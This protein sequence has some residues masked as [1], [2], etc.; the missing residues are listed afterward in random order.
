MWYGLYY[1]ILTRDCAEVASDRI[2]LSLGT[3][4]KMAVSVRDCGICGGELGDDGGPAAGGVM[5]SAGGGSGGGGAGRGG[6]GSGSGSGKGLGTIQLSCKHLFHM[7]C[8][9]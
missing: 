4:R 1:G 6:S 3:G 5:S 8:I 9:R 2:A 7:E